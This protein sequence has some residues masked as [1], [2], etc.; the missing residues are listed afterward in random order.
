MKMTEALKAWLAANCGARKDATE[1]ELRQAAG[2]A[3]ASGKLSVEEYAKLT[4]GAKTSEA[5]DFGRKLDALTEKIGMLIELEQKKTGGEDAAS[6]ASDEKKPRARQSDFSKALG[7][8]GDVEDRSEPRVRV[9]E[10]VES[11]THHRTAMIYPERTKRGTLHP[12]AGQQAAM[13]G[14]PLDL[15]SQRDK[16]LAGVWTKFQILAATSKFGGSTRLAWERLTDH[17]KSLLHFL[18]EEE[19]WDDSVDGV[20]RARKGYPGGLKQL[21]DSTPSGGI[22]AC[23]IVFDDLVVQAPLLHGELYPLV[24]E[25]PLDRGRRIEGVATGTV[26]GAWGGID[27]TP[28]SLFGTNNY[29]TSFDTTVHRW[30]GAIEIG[31]DFLS[32]S[33][34]DFSKHVTEQY[35]ERLLEDLDDVIA[36]GDGTTQPLGV[37]NSAGTTVAFGGAMS[38]ANMEALRFAVAK[39]EHRPNLIHTAVF[40]GTETSYRRAIGIPVSGTDT[41]RVFGTLTG[42]AYDSYTIMNKPFKINASLTN[43]QIWY[44]VLGRYRMYRRKGLTVRT[45]TEGQTL[46]LRNTMLVIV[47][48]RYGGQLERGA[49]AARTITA[50]N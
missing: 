18:V 14:R 49:A 40:C 48:A 36:A 9:K 26:T 45:V 1:S 38:L 27:A 25:V 17:E 33:P 23:P 41:R 43:E 19:L 24:N 4:S 7:R 22:E 30:Q 6:S 16:A 13:H 12:L 37:L 2:E 21:I 47:M 10:A 11:Y 3:L 20:D 32:D 44:A 46:G 8:M 35:G 42:P 15:P 39:Q 28:I 34:I 29:V 5:N 50:P 31:L